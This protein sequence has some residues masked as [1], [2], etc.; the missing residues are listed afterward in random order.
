M[1][2]PIDRDVKVHKA[3]EE[4][5]AIF[6]KALPRLLRNAGDSSLQEWASWSQTDKLLYPVCENLKKLKASMTSS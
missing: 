3:S 6:K 1:D 5:I 2:A 4:V